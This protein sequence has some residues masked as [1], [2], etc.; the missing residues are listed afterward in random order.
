MKKMCIIAKKGGKVHV[1]TIF[2]TLFTKIH[3]YAQFF[4]VANIFSYFSR[5]GVSSIITSRWRVVRAILRRK[6]N[7]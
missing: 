5:W 6:W 3:I 4:T 7:L 2:G 1:Y